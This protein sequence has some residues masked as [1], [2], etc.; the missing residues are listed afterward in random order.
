MIIAAGLGS[1][2]QNEMP[3]PL[4]EV[5]GVTLI[6]R[7]IQT[8]KR[9]GIENF[10]VVSGY[11]GEQLRGFLDQNKDCLGVNIVHVINEDYRRGNGLSV[12]AAKD[13]LRENFILT[14]CDH[15]YDASIVA[16]LLKTGTMKDGLTL[17]VD[18]RLDSDE[19]D[20]DDVTRVYQEEN[21]IRSIGKG[22][23]DYNCFDVGVFYCSP[24]LFEAI[25][26]SVETTGDES[27]SGGVRLL[28]SED[29][30]GVMDIGDRFWCDVDN[31]SEL[32]KARELCI[33]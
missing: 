15:L 25:G 6:E 29:R 21:Y 14:M 8:N 24:R 19:I 33:A 7:V 27:L 20:L 2:M 22:M 18:S 5:R 12:A 9:A 1:R 10:Y 16:D 4:L 11:K 30:A 3:K 26:R 28:A 23:A 32:E 13:V 31:S 17:A